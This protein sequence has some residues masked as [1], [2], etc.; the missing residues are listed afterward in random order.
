METCEGCNRS[1]DDLDC[2]Y[3][4]KECQ[5]KAGG[6][7]IADTDRKM[8]HKCITDS[9]AELQKVGVVKNMGAALLIGRTIGMLKVGKGRLE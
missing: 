5:E 4:C 9:L 8:L 6:Y 2:A 1:A 7:D 3:L